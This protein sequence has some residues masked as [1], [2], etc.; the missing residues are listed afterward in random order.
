MKTLYILRHGKS[1][2]E[3]P[4]ENDFN[5]PLL[6][7]GQRRT[8]RISVHIKEHNLPVDLIISSPAVRAFET[9]KI[10]AQEI[11]CELI[12]DENLYPGF[13]SDIWEVI[14]SQ[15][16]EIDSLMI[17]GHNPGVTS[18]IHDLIDSSFDWLPTSGLGIISFNTNTWIQTPIADRISTKILTPKM[19]K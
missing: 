12:T 17:V 2:W 8:Q 14:F 7:K 13:S 18:M 16:D 1:S 5:R 3:Q 9:A 10:V 19:L 4:E 11:D 6:P 15:P